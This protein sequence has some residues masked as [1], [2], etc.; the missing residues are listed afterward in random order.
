MILT[1]VIP[2]PLGDLLLTGDGES[3]SGLYFPEHP[4]IDSDGPGAFEEAVAQ[5]EEWFE[6]KRTEFDLKLDPQ[7][8]LFQRRIWE[9][10]SEIP[11]GKTVSYM[12]IAVRAGNPRAARPAGQ[13]IGRNPI[14]IIVPCHRVI[15]SSGALTG[16]GGGMDRKRWLLEHEK[17]T[18]GTL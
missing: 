4:P 16:Y 15:G 8:T 13:A 2:T 10:L 1:R 17:K 18:A 5:L 11:Y 9:A 7:G 12:D 14:A 3:V 6:G